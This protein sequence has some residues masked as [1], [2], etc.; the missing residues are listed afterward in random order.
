MPARNM[1]GNRKRAL[2]G[3]TDQDGLKAFV[4]RHLLALIDCDIV[5]VSGCIENG[6]M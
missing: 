4:N 1:L 3:G 6:I 5:T 2:I